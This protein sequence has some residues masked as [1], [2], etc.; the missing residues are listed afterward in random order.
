MDVKTRVVVVVL[1]LPVRDASQSVLPAI[2]CQLLVLVGV[3]LNQTEPNQCVDFA[4]GIAFGVRFREF[5]A[6]SSPASGI[7]RRLRKISLLPTMRHHA[8]F[9]QFIMLSLEV[10]LEGSQDRKKCMPII[11]LDS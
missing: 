6:R 2:V 4:I 7:T 3:G 1:R 10:N 8:L 9:R 11:E 5:D